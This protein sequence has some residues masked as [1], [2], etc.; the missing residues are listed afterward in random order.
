M[1]RALRPCVKSVSHVSTKHRSWDSMLKVAVPGM[2][3]IVRKECKERSR[4]FRECKMVKQKGSTTEE[5]CT[6]PYDQ[7]LLP[8]SI[9]D[10]SSTQSPYHASCYQ[11]QSSEGFLLYPP[12]S[13]IQSRIL[14]GRI[15]QEEE[16]SF[17]VSEQSEGVDATAPCFKIPYSERAFSL[18]IC[19][20]GRVNSSTAR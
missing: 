1:K 12:A 19:S 13:G 20:I 14:R 5:I 8:F 2:R 4:F 10:L 9:D 17:S 11:V 18:R 7:N 3:R 16:E 15:S 6:S